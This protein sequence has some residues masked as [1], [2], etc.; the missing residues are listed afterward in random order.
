MTNPFHRPPN[1]QLTARIANIRTILAEI[2]TSSSIRETLILLGQ[3]GGRHCASCSPHNTPGACGPTCALLRPTSR[4]YL[5][6]PAWAT[7][8]YADVET[9]SKLVE[10]MDRCAGVPKAAKVREWEETAEKL[11]R[12]AMSR[13]ECKAEDWGGN[14]KMLDPNAVLTPDWRFEGHWGL[15]QGLEEEVAPEDPRVNP[16]L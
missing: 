6:V 2:K 10:D 14:V 3:K 12:S 9:Y 11:R 1:P 7:V 5:A 8:V 13:N 15:G 16:F 4:E